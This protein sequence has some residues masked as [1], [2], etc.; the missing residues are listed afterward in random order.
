MTSILE[1]AETLHADVEGWLGAG[2]LGLTTI[3]SLHQHARGI[4]GAVGEIGVHHGKYF[5]GLALLRQRRES[6]VAIDLFEDQHLNVDWSGRGDREVFMGHLKRLEIPI[7][8]LVIHKANSLDLTP[9]ELLK[10]SDGQGYRLFSIDGGHQANIVLH[11]LRLVEAALA[12]DGI[13]I[14]DDFYNPDWPGVNEALFRYL[15]QGQLRPVAYGDNKLFLC[16]GE[17]YPGTLEWLGSRVL[18][19]TSYFKQ[20]ELAGF[21]CYHLAP[22]AVSQPLLSEAY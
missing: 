8:G 13:V 6:A 21:P 3:F 11:D 2:A 9:Q 17:A 7:E 16:T 5:I 20:V 10:L 4:S 19:L 15:P 12:P 14:L 18:P 1:Y 22:P